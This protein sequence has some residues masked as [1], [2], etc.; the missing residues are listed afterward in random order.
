[1]NPFIVPMTIANA[2]WGVVVT[3]IVFAT[4]VIDPTPAHAKRH[5][6]VDLSREQIAARLDAAGIAHNLPRAA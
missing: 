3:G 2:C 5:V 1:M 6:R 4:H